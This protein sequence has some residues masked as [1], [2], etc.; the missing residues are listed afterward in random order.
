MKKYLFLATALLLIMSMSLSAQ[1]V[2]NRRGGNNRTNS[3][4]RRS[5]Q[6]NRMTSQQRAD[7]MAKQLD[8]SVNET[9]KV[10]A[11][12]EK[13]DAKRAEQVA[14]HRKQRDLGRQNRD[15]NREEMRALRLKEVEEHNA[16]LEKIIGKDK[17]EKWNDIRSQV[18]EDNRAG[19]RD[20]SGRVSGYY[21]NGRQHGR[22]NFDNRRS[23]QNYRMTPKERVDLMTKELD[24]TSKEA[25]QVLTLSEKQ[26]AT[27]LKQVRE[28]RD[29]RGTGRVN[30]DERREEMWELRKEEVEKHNAELEKIIGKNKVAKWNELR[31]DVRSTNRSGRR[32][33]QN[34]NW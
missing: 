13:Q 11:L 28:N 15:V 18:R 12:M 27:R 3:N 32:N 19:R 7:L 20:G 23:N 2:N 1:N 4:N 21:H 33:P 17:F 30:R 8:L 25:A 29:Q 31:K 5:E 22:R 16:D 14:E 34:R 26:E 24:L 9:A 6:V 10:H